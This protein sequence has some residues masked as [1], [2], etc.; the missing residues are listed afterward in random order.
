MS[1]LAAWA[2]HFPDALVRLMP[3]R[4]EEIHQQLLHAPR[5][6]VCGHAVT[7][8]N[9]ERIEDLAIDIELKLTMGGIANTHRRAVFITTEPIQFHFGQTAVTHDAVHGLKFVRLASNRTQ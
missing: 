8:S 1:K 9:V 6:F 7:L 3:L 2:A 5:V 4:L